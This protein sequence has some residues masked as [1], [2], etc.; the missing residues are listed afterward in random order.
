MKA[1]HRHAVPFVWKGEKELVC[2][3]E[4]GR[5]I[6]S[7]AKGRVSLFQHWSINEHSHGSKSLRVRFADLKPKIKEGVEK[8]GCSLDAFKT[9]EDNSV[10]WSKMLFSMVSFFSR[11]I[12]SLVA[13]S[14]NTCLGLIFLSD[15]CIEAP[16]TYQNPG[17]I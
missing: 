4:S 16:P 10:V 11:S 15:R 14:S 2:L 3:D 9:L 7:L 8:H 5:E 17:K 12:I 1:G 6:P 13:V